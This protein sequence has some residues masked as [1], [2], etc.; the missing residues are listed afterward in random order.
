MPPPPPRRAY[1][2]LL[3]AVLSLAFVAC[4]EDGT[5][6]GSTPST[7]GPTSGTQP[8]AAA[9]IGDPLAPLPAPA[10]APSGGRVATAMALATQVRGGGEPGAAALLTALRLSG[11]GVR[12]ANGEMLVT[13]ASPHQGTVVEAWEIRPLVALAREHRTVLVPLEELAMLVRAAAPQL[14][15]TDVEAELLA[16]IRRHATDDAS[17]LAFWATFTSALGGTTAGFGEPDLLGAG[18][19]K[20]VVVNGLQASLLVRRLGTDLLVRAH[21]TRAASPFRA[22]LEWFA[23]RPLHAAAPPRACQLSPVQQTITDL[24][25]YG[26]GVVVGGAKV[27][28]LGFGGLMDAIFGGTKAADAVGFATKA[29]GALLAYGQFAMTYN[30][31]EAEIALDDPPLPRTREP[32]P[33]SGEQRKLVASIRMTTGDEQAVNCFRM[34]FN[35]VGLDFSLPQDGPAKGATVAW[36][37]IEGFNQAAEALHR[38]PEAIVQFVDDPANRIQDGSAWRFASANAVVNQKTGDDGTVRI[39]VEGRGQKQALPR[40]AGRVTKHATVGIQ[41]ALKGA[42]LFGDMKDASTAAMGGAAA[43]LSLPVDLLYRMKWASAA[44]LTFP[45]RDWGE[46]KGWSGTVDVIIRTSGGGPDPMMPMSSYKGSRATKVSFDFTNNVG[47]WRASETLWR[48]EETLL[49]D[50]ECRVARR[51]NVRTTLRGGGDA[52]LQVGEE[53][54]S[55]ARRP[56]EDADDPV[57]FVDFGYAPERTAIGVGEIELTGTETGTETSCGTTTPV[58]DESSRGYHPLG[59]TYARIPNP[60]E[61]SELSGTSTWPFEDEGQGTKGII[62]MSWRLHRTQ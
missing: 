10:A 26:S 22:P 41:V 5:S 1:V 33:R 40:G 7:G 61:Q 51:R 38:G 47:S 46:G 14:G 50:G 12:G 56:P 42:D 49:P 17:P 39:A 3:T 9:P 44:K 8:T 31:L 16:G 32:R 62:T 6:S 15:A 19:A 43:L 54:P 20:D 60:L 53:G 24:V 59:S 57:A 25:A 21:P 28:D 4:R 27:G 45:V 52:V 36:T 29:A 37:G 13:P 48:F 30:A 11:I 18:D 23:P 34:M 35:S 58:N 55:D 2:L